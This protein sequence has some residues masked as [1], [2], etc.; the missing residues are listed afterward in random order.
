[1]INDGD[2]FGVVVIG[3]GQAG[4]SVAYYLR[5][6]GL[7]AG[8]DFV[9]LD[10]GP[11]TGGAWQH[12]WEALRIGSAHRIND[13]PGMDALG[14]S[15]ESAD[16]SAPAKVVV[17][18][19]YGRYEQFYELRVHRPARVTSVYNRGIDLVARLADQTGEHELRTDVLV[20]ATGT[21]GAPFI[22]W[23]PGLD[24]FRGRHV[25]TADYVSATE[26][27]GQRVVVV[28]AGTSAIG[29]LLELENVAAEVTWVSRRPVEFLDEGDFDIEARAAA[30]AKQDAAARDGRALPS[31]VSGTGIPKTRR[32]AAAVE[33][34][35]LV[36]LPMF[37]RIE[38]DGVR[39]EDGSFQS[40]D[41]IVWSTGFRPELRHLAPLKLREKAGGIQVGNSAAWKDPRIFFA[42]YGPGA[43]TIGA[44]RAGRI[45]ARQVVA[46]LSN[47]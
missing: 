2:H 27:A 21:W 36:A 17:A 42:G 38:A 47:L 43:S 26:F 37:T 15:F 11:R 32:I 28:G 29:F 20:N 30:V 31:I 24:Q 8:I 14:L 39:F 25:H 44:N 5:K 13:L 1:V 40:A 3:A 4:L 23:Y 10:R 35:L 34:G 18:D 22:P 19:Y 9:V 45:I 6:L 7:K 46:A 33:R 41:A 16:R 12:R